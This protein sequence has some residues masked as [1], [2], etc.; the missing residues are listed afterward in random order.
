MIAVGK[1]V[2]E[3]LMGADSALLEPFRF[4]RFAEGRLHPVS[5]SPFPWS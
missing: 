2:A 3:E 4:S 5:N 1:L